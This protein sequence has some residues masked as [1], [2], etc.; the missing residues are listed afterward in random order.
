ML[1]KKSVKE[2]NA[3]TGSANCETVENINTTTSAQQGRMAPT[4]VQMSEAQLQ[5]ILAGMQAQLSLHVQQS[6]QELR[7]QIEE[8][9]ARTSTA[10]DQRSINNNPARGN[11]DNGISRFNGEN[12]VAALRLKSTQRLRT[13][14]RYSD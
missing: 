7:G 6:Q 13:K 14:T 10:C 1:P 8:I 5:Q 12:D 2:S 11:F 9:R 3:E 4:V